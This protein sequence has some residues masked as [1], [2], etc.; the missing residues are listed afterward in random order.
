MSLLSP[1][2]PRYRFA[3]IRY[4]RPEEVHKGRVVPARVETV[5]IFL[6]DVWSCNPSRLE[7]EQMTL[8]F[9]KQLADKISDESKDDNQAPYLL[10]MLLLCITLVSAI[11]YVISFPDAPGRPPAVEQGRW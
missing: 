6:P 4:H 3:E 7:W 5:V 8:N 2:T 1:P 10:S 9:K 11:V